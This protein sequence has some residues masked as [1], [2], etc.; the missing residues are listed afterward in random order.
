MSPKKGM[1]EMEDIF[2]MGLIWSVLERSL[3]YYSEVQL[4]TNLKKF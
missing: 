4:N 3:L 2:T 1:E